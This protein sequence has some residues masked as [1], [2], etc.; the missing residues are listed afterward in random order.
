MKRL[1]TEQFIEKA[2]AVHGDKYDYSLVDYR[3]AKTKVK[4]ICPEHGSFEQ[5]PNNHLSGNNCPKCSDKKLNTEEFIEKARNV[6]GDRYNYS[7]V[8]YNNK[9]TKV[10]I[11]CPIHGDFEQRPDSHLNGNGC[12]HCGRKTK[13]TKTFIRESNIVHNDKYNYSLVEYK[14]NS[15]K[16]KIICPEHGSFEQT[17]SNHL[18]G[19]G[20]PKCVGFYNIHYKKLNIPTYDTFQSKLEP[21]GVKCRRN[22]EDNNVLEV[23]CMYCDRWYIPSYTSVQRKINAINGQATG[24]SNLYCS[25]E[26][27]KACPTYRQIKYPK[28]FKLNT[29]RE[30]QPELRKLVLKRDN[31]TCQK[32]N[33]TNTELHCHHYEGVEV[34]PVESADI[35]QCITLCKECH[36]NIHKKDKC[37]IKDY[38]RGKC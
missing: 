31:Y 30:V 2:K 36:N 22:K 9:Q 32:C 18:S 3:N 26:C 4:I 29:S 1:T 27:K 12:P 17:P 35:D 13:T 15:I 10:K 25:N 34:N 19:K 20:C 37:G 7:I 23:K 5:T 24:E 8:V 16:V 21:Y 6:H 33:A 14:N 28:D 38:Q 11:I